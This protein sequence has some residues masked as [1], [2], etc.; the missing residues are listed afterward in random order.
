[1]KYIAKGLLD[2]SKKTIAFDSI[3]QMKKYA[4]AGDISI[5]KKDNKNLILIM[6]QCVDKINVFFDSL[7]DVPDEL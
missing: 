1:M 7:S 6:N 3:E 4:Q 5:R 2:D